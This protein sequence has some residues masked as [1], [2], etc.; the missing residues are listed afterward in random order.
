MNMTVYGNPIEITKICEWT[1]KTFIV[2]QK[3]KNQRF[4]NKDAM[5]SWRK[6]KNRENVNCI[7]CEKL[8]E[9]Y[10]RILHPRSGKLT[11][12]CSDECSKGSSYNRER[13]KLLFTNKNPMSNKSSRDKIKESKLKKYGVPYYNNMEKVT[14][15][16][17]D[18]YGVPCGFYLPSSKSN[19]RR[20]SKF[21]RKHYIEVLKTYPDAELEKYLPDVKK[22]VDIYIPSIKRVIECH[23]DYWHCNPS[24]CKS[25]YYNKV[26]H[27]TA[28][29]IW[30]RDLDK[31]KLIESFGYEVIVVWE[32][33]N[34]R[35]RH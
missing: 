19:G 14:K 17:M 11:Q 30:K 10:K 3:H 5:Y 12:Y 31:K 2:D 15:T 33:T 23:G 24:K 9:R 22:S 32:N 35:F 26:V 7:T 27:M 18:R 6:S 1:G 29:E 34:K 21:Q 20:I 13:C 8:F 16:M 4:I 25:D 28:E